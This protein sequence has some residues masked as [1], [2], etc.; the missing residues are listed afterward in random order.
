[1]KRE[2]LHRIGREHSQEGEDAKDSHQCTDDAGEGVASIHPIRFH[3]SAKPQLMEACHM[4]ACVR[5]RQRAARG[6]TRGLFETYPTQR[7]AKMRQIA[8]IRSIFK[9][10]AKTEIDG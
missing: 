10:P 5:V 1:M 9:H 3:L 4:C 6:A 2:D 7:A 8:K